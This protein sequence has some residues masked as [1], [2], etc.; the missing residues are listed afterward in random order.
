MSLLGAKKNTL[1]ITSTDGVE[2]INFKS[3]QTEYD[4]LQLPYDGVEQF[5]NATLICVEPSIN[6]FRGVETPQL[7]FIAYDLDGV[8]YDF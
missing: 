4:S 2:F 3:S 5:Y 1:K 6:N 7:Q 8:K